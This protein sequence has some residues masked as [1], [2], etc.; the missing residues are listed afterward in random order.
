MWVAVALACAIVVSVAGCSA[1]PLGTPLEGTTWLLIQY[2]EGSSMAP[3][4]ETVRP[5]ARFEAGTVSG[6]SGCNSFTGRYVVSGESMSISQVATTQ[7]A[8]PEP[9]MS[10][11]ASFLLDLATVASYSISGSQLTLRDATSSDVLVFATSR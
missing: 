11:E 9:Q 2:R 5:E 3:V 4:P 6:S 8:C 7:M 10:V 1:S